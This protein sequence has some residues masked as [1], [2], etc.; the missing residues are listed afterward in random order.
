MTITHYV[1]LDV[2]KETIAIAYAHANARTDP[3]F[4]GTTEFSP[5]KV[6]RALSKLAPSE[7]IKVCFEAGPCGYG[8]ARELLSLEFDCEVIAPSRVARRRARQQVAA[9]LLRQGKRYTEGKAWT[10]RYQIYLSRLK[11]EGPILHTVFAE[12]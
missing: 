3:I 4:I 1:S 6:K 5:L 12:S 2:H 9:F 11:L 10:K 7:S 8:L